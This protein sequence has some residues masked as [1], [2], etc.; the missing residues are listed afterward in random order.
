MTTKQKVLAFGIG[1]LIALSLLGCGR[2]T[3]AA[4]AAKYELSIT[5]R[6]TASLIARVPTARVLD[7][8]AKKV[9]G[10]DA[11]TSKQECET[12]FEMA[13]IPGVSFTMLMTEGLKYGEDFTIEH[14]CEV[15]GEAA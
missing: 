14:K 6:P 2:E 8:P 4:E 1:A 5:L 3:V 11:F 12:H 13:D 9:E 10:H 7:F 15:A